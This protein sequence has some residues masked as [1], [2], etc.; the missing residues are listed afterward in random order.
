MECKSLLGWQPFGTP[1]TLL[2]ICLIT[3]TCYVNVE[4]ILEH[5]GIIHPLVITSK[6]QRK[7]VFLLLND[8]TK[9]V[10]NLQITWRWKIQIQ[11]SRWKVAKIIFTDMLVQQA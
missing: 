3:E 2:Y 6:L 9:L 7:F 11:F 1:T 8:I 5:L 10:H 4:T